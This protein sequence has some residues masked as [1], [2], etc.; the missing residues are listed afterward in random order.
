MADE[1][2][3]GRE[4]CSKRPAARKVIDTTCGQTKESRNHV[5]Q[6]YLRRGCLCDCGFVILVL[7]IYF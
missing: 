6:F 2:A 4:M 1:W 7:F 5:F 3:A